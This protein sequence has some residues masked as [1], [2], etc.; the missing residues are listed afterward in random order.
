MDRSAA[1]SA[2]I[3][4]ATAKKTKH[5][6]AAMGGCTVAIDGSL[7]KLVPFF[8]RQVRAH[9][10]SLLGKVTSSLVHLVTADDGS[11]KGAAVLAATL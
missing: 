7:Y 6:Q 1:L 3:I 10:D 8:Q 5:L 11:G 9:L 4:A 2:V